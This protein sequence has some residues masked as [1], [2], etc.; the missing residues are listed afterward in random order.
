MNIAY[1]QIHDLSE[2]DLD[3]LY[4]R[5]RDAIDSNWPKISILTP[6]ERKANMLAAIQS[7]IDNEWPGLNP[8]S[9]NDTY[10]MLKIVDLDSGITMGFVSGYLIEGSSFNVEGK[11][12]DGR[13]SFIAPDENGS[14]NY[15]YTE[16]SQIARK[17]F[18]NA[19]GATHSLYRNIPTD[20]IQHRILRIRANAGT[21]EL[22][23]DVDSPTLGPAFRNILI[24]HL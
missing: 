16:P 17:D 19:I 10:I 1:I 18:H 3:D 9:P 20:S 11:I 15:L 4:E 6:E 14:R 5:C 21:Y 13:H 8:H 2:I 24:Q 12:I 7:G 22:V 23:E